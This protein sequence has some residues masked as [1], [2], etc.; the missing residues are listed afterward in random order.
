MSEGEVKGS[1]VAKQL[2]EINESMFT[3]DKARLDVE[4]ESVSVRSFSMHKLA[5]KTQLLLDDIKRQMEVARAKVDSEIR[6]DPINNG[7]PSGKTTE[8]GIESAIVLDSKI[9][10]LASQINDARYRVNLAEAAVEAISTKKKAL[11]GLTQLH[12]TNYY[13]SK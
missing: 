8:N 2:D 13:T 9:Q 3:I 11:D 7:F 10:E 6:R 12:S 1:E 4:W 5:A